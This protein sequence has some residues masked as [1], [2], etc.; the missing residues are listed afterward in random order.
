MR[1]GGDELDCEEDEMEDLTPP[2]L[3]AVREV[4][5]HM[6]SGK[7]MKES[8]QCYLDG[9]LD[10]FSL[11]LRRNWIL[12]QKGGSIPQLR[13]H[14]AQ[15]FWNLVERGLAGQP[16][17]EAL[18][19]LEIEVERAAERE[20]DEHLAALPF[21]VLIPLLLFQFPAYLLL[22]LGPMLRELTRQMGGG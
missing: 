7:A 10:S 17:H 11:E 6:N 15:S 13:S 21:K 19:V 14:L 1:L 4:R 16:A 2:L 20:L 3:H 22:L 9:T 8:L 12:K 18:G 5:W